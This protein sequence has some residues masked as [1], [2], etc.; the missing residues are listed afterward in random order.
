MTVP[1]SAV[2]GGKLFNGTGF[3][4]GELQIAAGRFAG[5][6]GGAADGEVVDATGCYVIPGL[7]DL[8]FHGSAGRRRVRRR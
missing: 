7:V 8:H 6:V 2:V 5:A 3:E 4:E 1:V